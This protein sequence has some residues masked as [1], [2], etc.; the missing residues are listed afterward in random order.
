M[1]NYTEFVKNYMNKKSFILKESVDDIINAINKCKNKEEVRKVFCE[2]FLTDYKSF[3]QLFSVIPEIVQDPKNP[4]LFRWKFKSG[5]QP[6]EFLASD[7]ENEEGTPF[8]E[9]YQDFM[10]YD[11]NLDSNENHFKHVYGPNLEKLSKD[12]AKIDVFKNNIATFKDKLGLKDIKTDKDFAKSDFAKK[13]QKQLAKIVKLSEDSE[14]LAFNSKLSDWEKFGKVITYKSIEMLSFFAT[15]DEKLDTQTM[16]D[17]MSKVFTDED[18]NYFNQIENI[19]ELM[20]IDACLGTME[21]VNKRGMDNSDTNDNAEKDLNLETY[22]MAMKNSKSGDGKKTLDEYVERISKKYKDKFTTYKKQ[23]E[24]A[25]DKGREEILESEKTDTEQTFTDPLTNTTEK[26]IGR[27]GH[28]G[29]MTFIKNNEKLNKSVEAIKGQKW[30]IFNCAAKLLI[31][32][33][34]VIEEG[35]KGIQKMKQDIAEGL[36]QMRNAYKSDK[37]PD[38]EKRAENISQGKEEGCPTEKEGRLEAELENMSVALRK[39]ENEVLTSLNELQSK[40][41]F[42]EIEDENGE[43]IAVI[44][45][46]IGKAIQNKLNVLKEC[47][48][49]WNATNKGIETILADNEET[50]EDNSTGTTAD[51]SSEEQE[52]SQNINASYK[53]SNTNVINEVDEVKD[54]TTKATADAIEQAGGVEVQDD[55]KAKKDNDARAEEVDDSSKEAKDPN[56][57]DKDNNKPKFEV[58]KWRDQKFNFNMNMMPLSFG[59]LTPE[60]A[61]ILSKT[62]VIYSKFSDGDV[63][64]NLDGLSKYFTLLNTKNKLEVGRYLAPDETIIKSITAGQ[65]MDGCEALFKKL[66]DIVP[67][68]NKIQ[69][70]GVKIPADKHAEFVQEVQSVQSIDKY[71]D[72]GASSLVVV[73]CGESS[74]NDGSADLIQIAQGQG[75]IQGGKAIMQL[76]QDMHKAIEGADD[77][78]IDDRYIKF[79]QMVETEAAKAI[80]LLENKEETAAMEKL[81]KAGGQETKL[82]LKTMAESIKNGKKDQIHRMWWIN[83]FYWIRANIMKFKNEA[84][85]AYSNELLLNEGVKNDLTVEQMLQMI[86]TQILPP[87][88]NVEA[89]KAVYY[90]Q[91]AKMA[92]AVNSIKASSFEIIKK[93]KEAEN[94]PEVSPELQKILDMCKSLDVDSY[95]LLCTAEVITKLSNKS[96]KDSKAQDQ[97]KEGTQQQDEQPKEGGTQESLNWLADEFYKYI[98]G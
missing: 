45:G 15:K 83:R 75:T 26:R 97:P 7:G 54:D 62:F 67:L 14:K 60:T 87:L 33:L 2:K 82:E 37:L 71:K 29:P 79:K 38:Y 58:S 43:K 11:L 66:N 16:R 59:K 4:K 94:K 22:R 72:N 64:S 28:H 53:N 25:F 32:F 49:V 55:P 8:T 96:E 44:N 47:I 70:L 78:S 89:A 95:L 13:L 56:S 12:Q 63:K 57:N 51:A 84:L 30:N 69:S 3:E 39:Y 85:W 90:T 48:K 24:A 6:K 41:W 98:R 76:T 52:T 27:L 77:K 21:D 31:K 50:E 92:E 9:A 5:G 36:K 42:A 35:S 65:F 40:P 1:S 91:S 19:D 46:E 61:D 93:F 34:E 74:K 86:D 20:N 80:K 17:Y 68:M 73:T 23:V 10:K 18:D 88:N 81:F